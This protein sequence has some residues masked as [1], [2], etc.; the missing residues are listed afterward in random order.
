MLTVYIGYDHREPIAYQVAKFSIEQRAT[1]PVDVKPLDIE[2]LTEMGLMKRLV[3]KFGGQAWD[4]PSDAPASTEFAISRFLVP[5]I[6]QGG[7]ALFMDCDMLVTGDVAEL[8]PLL[9]KEK[10][11][12]CVKHNHQPTESVKMDNQ[13]Q[14]RYDRKN[15]S[16][17]MAFNCDHPAN[18]RLTLSHIWEVPGRYLH[19]FCWLDDDEIG[20]LPA[21]WNWLV[22]VQ[23]KPD[24]LFIAHYTLG[25]PWFPDWEPAEYDGLWENEFKS[26]DNN[27]T[28]S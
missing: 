25:G 4:V 9:D 12:M 11:V 15:W 18:R 3:L 20:E 5:L 24:E 8:I 16:S 21:G 22:N 10:A 28:D 17:V 27:R 7:W 13:A 14:T 6:H 2:R 1:I 19:Q 26:F 23:P